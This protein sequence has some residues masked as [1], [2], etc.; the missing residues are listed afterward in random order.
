VSIRHRHRNS[1]IT[2]KIIFVFGSFLQT[3]QAC[4]HWHP[5]R[6]SGSRS[7]SS[8]PLRWQVPH[9]SLCT[10]LTPSHAA[11]TASRSPQRLPGRVACQ[12]FC[13]MLRPGI[14]DP[15][16]LKAV[17][18]SLASTSRLH[19]HNH[20]NRLCMALYSETYHT[21]PGISHQRVSIPFSNPP[22]TSLCNRQAPSPDSIPLTPASAMLC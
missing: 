1:M 16:A 12:G 5:S 7:P 17:R 8:T 11:P 10:R 4:H 14:A 22:H 2:M 20:H 18:V 3:D 19:G 13:K 15:V 21:F 6:T 9:A